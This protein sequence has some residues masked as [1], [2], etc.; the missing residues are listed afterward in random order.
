MGDKHVDVT[1]CADCGCDR[2]GVIDLSAERP[3]LR[4]FQCNKSR[5]VKNVGDKQR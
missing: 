1:K 2:G 3:V 5:E 4:C